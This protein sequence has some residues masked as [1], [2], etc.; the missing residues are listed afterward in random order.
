MAQEKYDGDY[1]DSLW[2]R[3]IEQQAEKVA[4]REP[5]S[6][7]TEIAAELPPGCALDAGC[8][9]G[10]ETR[11]LVARGWKVKAVDFSLTALEYGKA[12]ARDD[13]DAISDRIE[14]V[15]VDLGGWTP[16]PA[17]FDLV[18]SLYV[19]IAGQVAGMVE[20]LAEGVMPGGTLLMVG[21]RPID[22]T[23]GAKTSAADQNQVSVEAAKTVLAPPEWELKVAEE[24]PRA[25]GQGVDA[26]ILARRNN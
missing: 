16:E 19:H 13:G 18:V 9:H 1:W 24:R 6:Y 5:H 15:Q 14:W 2:S 26:V 7:L 22:P 25:H 20:R 11:W 12:A 3:T 23:T 21:H 4:L 10:V 17:K 8:G